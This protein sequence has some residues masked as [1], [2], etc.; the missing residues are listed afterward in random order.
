MVTAP[1]LGANRLSRAVDEQN[2]AVVTVGGISNRGVH[3]YAGRTSSE[4]Q[5]V[6][7]SSLQRLVEFCLKKAAKSMLVQH[8]VRGVRAKFANDFRI[9]GIANQKSP[10]ATVRSD[11]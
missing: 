7:S 8:N 11:T 2:T 1:E 9:P 10:L 5:I 6:N 3:A 4:D